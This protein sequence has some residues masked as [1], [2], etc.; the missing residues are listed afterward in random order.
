M[1][2]R[3]YVYM[4]RCRDG[5]LYTGAT[6]DVPARVAK[7]NSGKGA[8]YTRSRRPVT[9]VWR[10]RA[11]DKSRALRLEAKLKRLTR[12]QKLALISAADRARRVSPS[13]GEKAGG[14]RR[15]R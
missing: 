15:S 9:L 14:G 10:R 8:R 3:W 13:I 11:Q 7:H 12:A 4:V 1:S 2:A 5:S 6:D